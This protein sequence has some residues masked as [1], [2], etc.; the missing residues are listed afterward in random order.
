MLQLNFFK[1]ITFTGANL[2]GL[3]VSFGFFGM[4]FF[5][6]LFMQNV[7][8]FSATGAG[9]RQLPSTLAVMVVAIVS[10]RI[11]G[12]IGA[13]VPMTVGMVFLG[14]G[15]LL[16]LPCRPPPRTAPTGGSS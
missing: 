11:V 1:N 16:F 7:Q 12:R 8:G 6:A 2:V 9:V 14:S 15:I 4:L 5:L 13:R 10:G 3:L